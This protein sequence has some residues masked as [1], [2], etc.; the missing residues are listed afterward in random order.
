MRAGGPEAA[1]PERITA[2]PSR[3]QHS[4]FQESS[5]LLPSAPKSEGGGG[6]RRAPRSV[7]VRALQTLGTPRKGAGAGAAPGAA[8]EAGCIVAAAVLPARSFWNIQVVCAKKPER[9]LS[10]RTWEA[11]LSCRVCSPLQSKEWNWHEF[12][13]SWWGLEGGL[14]KESSAC[15]PLLASLQRPSC[16]HNGCACVCVYAR[17]C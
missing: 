9:L 16:M 15:R 4:K 12:I 2:T 7:C 14:Y 5:P 13:F 1:A 3:V 8:G 17:V 10:G 6:I 11:T